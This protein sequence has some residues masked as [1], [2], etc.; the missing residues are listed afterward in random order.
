MKDANS[1]TRSSLAHSGA[2]AKLGPGFTPVNRLTRY[3]Q[4]AVF[5]LLVPGVILAIVVTPK[6]MWES[7]RHPFWEM[8]GGVAGIL[9][10]GGLL[11]WLGLTMGRVGSDVTKLWKKSKAGTFLT[12]SAI[13]VLAF[14][15]Q[16]FT[17]P[18]FYGWYGDA[19]LFFCLALLLGSHLLLRIS[20]ALTGARKN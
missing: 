3:W 1:T 19:W 6:L 5:G 18:H 16:R 7:A 13:A 2:P 20:V 10:L 9:C 8:L 15:L 11:L 12:F 4:Y 17:G 14:V